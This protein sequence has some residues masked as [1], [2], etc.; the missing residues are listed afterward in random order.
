M[1]EGVTVVAGTACAMGEA[2]LN[3]EAL[4]KFG[5]YGEL[6]GGGFPWLGGICGAITL[7]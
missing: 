6:L 1:T 2:A 7:D 3:M 4:R 5:L